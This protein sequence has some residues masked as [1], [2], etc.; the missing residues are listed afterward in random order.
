V[1]RDKRLLARVALVIVA[2]L[3]TIGIWVGIEMYERN[4]FQANRDFLRLVSRVEAE[5]EANYPI[6]TRVE[7][8]ARFLQS[9]GLHILKFYDEEQI[10]IASTNY[11]GVSLLQTNRYEVIMRFDGDR[12]MTEWIARC[13]DRGTPIKPSWEEY[14][15][16]ANPCQN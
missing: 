10:A 8:V 15:R 16:N 2:L 9:K 11:F 4:R 1:V 7:V 6:G 13:T 12:R 3:A 5:L 14:T